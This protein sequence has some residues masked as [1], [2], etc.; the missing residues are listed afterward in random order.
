VRIIVRGSKLSNINLGIHI[1]YGCWMVQMTHSSDCATSSR[2][3]AEKST[4]SEES[5][6]ERGTGD[7][8]DGK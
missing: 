7:T 5:T 6:K 3:S 4:P 8:N 2:S 1:T